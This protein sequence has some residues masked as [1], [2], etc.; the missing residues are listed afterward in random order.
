[1]NVLNGGIYDSI[2][3]LDYPLRGLLQVRM[4]DSMKGGSKGKGFFRIPH[5]VS[6][7]A[8]DFSFGEIAKVA[9][10]GA[11]KDLEKR[12]SKNLGTKK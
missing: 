9:F 10:W 11:A 3:H 2:E 4:G 12:F 7:E 6:K 8:S 5:N 1:L